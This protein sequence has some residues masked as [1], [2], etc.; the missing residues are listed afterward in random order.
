VVKFEVC[1]NVDLFSDHYPIK[2]QLKNGNK[3]EKII[4]QIKTL[5]Y[6]KANWIKFENQ[7]EQIDINEILKSTDVDEI[8]EFIVTNII[9]TANESI[10]VK[11]SKNIFH[12]KIPKYLRM[13]VKHKKYLLKKKYESNSKR[14]L[15]LLSRVIKEEVNILRNNNWMKFTSNNQENPL[16]S[17]KFWRRINAL[18]NDGK[19]KNNYFPVMNHNNKQYKTDLEKANL[20]GSILSETFKDNEHDKYDKNFKIK[21][22]EEIKDYY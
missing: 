3:Q 7:L 14:D 5:D 17:K 20:F 13:L 8:N 4:N 9:K 12:T 2:I 6:S 16:S 1:I 21:I 19:V 18:K 22:E 15:N 10:P 11:N